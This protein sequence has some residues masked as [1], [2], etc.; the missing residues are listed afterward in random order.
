MDLFFYFYY[1]RESELQI[2]SAFRQSAAISAGPLISFL[3][4][5]TAVDPTRLRFIYTNRI[6]V[7][8]RLDVVHPSK[9]F[10][11]APLL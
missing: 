9:S 8:I 5:S 7:P 11:L 4:L 6:S 1:N 10:G 3:R 2:R